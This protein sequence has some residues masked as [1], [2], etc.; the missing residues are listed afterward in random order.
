VLALFSRAGFDDD[1]HEPG[2]HGEVTLADMY[3]HSG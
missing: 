1:L 2:A 3:R